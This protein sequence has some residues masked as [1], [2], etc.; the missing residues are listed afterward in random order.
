M[1][2]SQKK[3]DPP[4]SGSVLGGRGV[5]S[6]SAQIRMCHN[7]CIRKAVS[8]VSEDKTEPIPISVHEKTS[9]SF[10]IAKSNPKFNAFSVFSHMLIYSLMTALDFPSSPA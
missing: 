1:N 9:M 4:T 6:D 3:P 5:H 7:T 8:S 2:E 10:H